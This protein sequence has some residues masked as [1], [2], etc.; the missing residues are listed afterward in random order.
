M[1]RSLSFFAAP[2]ATLLLAG[3]SARAADIPWSFNWTPSM[4]KLISSGGA[5]NYLQISNEPGGTAAGNS[6]SVATNLKVFSDAPPIT[7]G[8]PTF[9][10][11]SP[12]SFNLALTDTT[13]GLVHNFL[14]TVQFGGYINSHAAAVTANFVG[15]TTFSNVQ[16]GSNLYTVNMPSY[17]PP[18]PP[19]SSNSGSLSVQ[20]SVTPGS[21]GKPPVIQG[22]PEPSTMALSCVGLSFFGLAGWRKRRRAALQLA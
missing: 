1:K 14:Y 16:I 8:S 21:G 20:I 5:T 15:P 19:G 2:L 11:S 22:A 12:V 18:G 10:G 17:T 7:L 4:T 13:S 6:N 3:T 9:T